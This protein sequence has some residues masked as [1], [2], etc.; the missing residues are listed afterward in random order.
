M[1]D[2]AAGSSG[3]EAVLYSVT[4]YPV[5]ERSGLLRRQAKT[6]TGEVVDLLAF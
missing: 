4:D 2:G 6:A 1:K 3:R 5:I